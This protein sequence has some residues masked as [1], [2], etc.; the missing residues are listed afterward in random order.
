MNDRLKIV[1]PVVVV[2]ALAGTWL[3]TRGDGEDAGA[4]SASGTV[5]ATTADL[6]FELPGRIRSVDVDE[7]DMVTAGQE[8]ARLDT[9][10]L[11]ANVEAARAQLG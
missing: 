11:E 2:A 9:R 8:L 10:E 1:I 5:E 3:A 7:G 4:L 6:G